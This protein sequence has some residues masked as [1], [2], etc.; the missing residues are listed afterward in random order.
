MTE[1]EIVHKEEITYF[2]RHM[3]DIAG[4]EVKQGI[5]YEKQFKKRLKFQS[6]TDW[7][8]Y[9]A[10]IDLLDDTEYA[11]I[12]AFEYQLGDLGNKNKDFNGIYLR[13]YGILNA[14]YLQ[15]SAFEELAC[16]LNYSSRDNITDLFKQLDIY[17]LR[18]IAGAHTLDYKYDP[19]ILEN[20]QKTSFRIYQ[21]YL[22]ET[23]NNISALS[24]HGKILEYNLLDILNE[25]EEK[26][27]ALLILITKHAIKNL[28]NDKNHR[29]ELTKQLDE[30]VKNLI[31]YLQID[32][33]KIHT[34]KKLKE[35][36]IKIEKL[37]KEYENLEDLA[38]IKIPGFED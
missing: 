3:L 22:E 5:D 30:K 13:L 6:K 17:K 11:I 4:N 28:V 2:L 33:N 35:E 12:S 23:G 7:K 25:Y 14:V 24:Q 37:L 32:K 10:S 34:E 9:R 1:K 26:A 18:N 38:M 15:M 27:R 29:V 8:R 31:D 20:E 16:L 21:C 19:T 36:R